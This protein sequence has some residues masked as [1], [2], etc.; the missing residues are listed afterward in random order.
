ME[1]VPEIDYAEVFR[2]LEEKD[3]EE[4]NLAQYFDPDEW[5]AMCQLERTRYKNIKIN[6]D[7]MRECG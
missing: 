3:Q 7:L 2:R 6:Y 5:R 1:G 4:C